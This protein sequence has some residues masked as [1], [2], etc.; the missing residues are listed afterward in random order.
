MRRM[1]SARITSRYCGW[2]RCACT[3][4][5][6]SNSA[7]TMLAPISR[8]SATSK[9]LPGT[10]SCPKMTWNQ[11]AR[12]AAPAAGPKSVGSVLLAR[13][14]TGARSVCVCR[15]HRAPRGVERQGNVA[16]GMCGRHETCFECRGR[17][18]DAA[19]QHAM[20]EAVELRRVRC[21]GLRV[22]GHLLAAE[23]QAEHAAYAV[24]AERDALP[25]GDRLQALGEQPRMRGEAVVETW[26][27]DQ[28][29]HR[30]TC[31]HRHRI[32]AQRARLVDRSGWR[33]LLHQVASPAIGADRHAAADDLA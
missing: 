4:A 21:S 31:R 19:L 16:I 26:R 28:L 7:T 23:E 13:V 29:Q 11:R 2:L 24:G 5:I 12:H 14:F 22:A 20:E 8:I 15:A 1:R 33:D 3:L 9:R 32:A 25:V 30:Q 17:E 27:L 6:E 10:S 18:I